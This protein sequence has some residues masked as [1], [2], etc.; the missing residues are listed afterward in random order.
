V[1]GIDNLF[2][3]YQKRQQTIGRRESGEIPDF[4][5]FINKKTIFCPESV[6]RCETDKKISGLSFFHG[7]H[8]HKKSRNFQ[9]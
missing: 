3:Q 7:R 6:K 4:V 1:F 2:Y 5:R 9:R 8:M